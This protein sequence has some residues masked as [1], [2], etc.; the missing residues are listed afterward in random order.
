M[1]ARRKLATDMQAIRGQDQGPRLVKQQLG[2][3]WSLL[4]DG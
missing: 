3:D 1:D 4:L 2:H